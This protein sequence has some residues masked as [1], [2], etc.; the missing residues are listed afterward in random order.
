MASTS[1]TGHAKNVANFKD[2]I[3][4]CTGLGAAYNPGKASIKPDALNSKF[5]AADESIKNL[6]RLSPV[7]TNAVNERE[8]LFAPL[9]QLAA[10][11]NSAVASSD[12]PANALADVKTFTRKLQGRRAVPKKDNPEG[13]GN[14]SVS[15]LSYDSRL[16]NLGKLTELLGSLP[17]YTPNEPELAVAG[18]RALLLDLEKANTDVMNSITPVANARAVRNTELYHLQTGLIKVA[19]DVKAYIKSVFTMK[20]P[21]FKQVASL[22]FRKPGGK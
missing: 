15:Q 3:A 16:E 13:A 1:E 7:L 9:R 6:N 21:Q 10:R 12:A 19:A 11:I 17:G 18:L 2:L 8:K 4:V 14:I 5:N 22:Q 20:S